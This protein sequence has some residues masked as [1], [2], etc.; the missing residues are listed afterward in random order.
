[1]LEYLYNKYSA[2]GK[3][4]KVIDPSVLRRNWLLMGPSKKYYP[5]V[6]CSVI[7]DINQVHVFSCADSCLYC[8]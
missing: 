8:Q 1:M 5:L 2:Q 6:Q 4:K 3:E 7:K